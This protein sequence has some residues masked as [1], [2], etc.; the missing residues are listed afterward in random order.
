MPS[1]VLVMLSLNFASL[2]LHAQEADTVARIGEIVITAKD[3]ERA[4]ND[5]GSQF[6]R[7][8]VEQR[9]AAVL[10]ALIDIVVISQ[11][12]EAEGLAEDEALLARLALLRQRVLHNVYISR[13]V[14]DKIADDEIRALYL[15]ET[16]KVEEVKARHILVKTP[17]EAQDIIKQLNEGGNFIALAKEKSTGPTGPSG[18]LLG[19]FRK[20]R[21]VPAFEQAAFALEPGKHTA[22]PVKTQ[23]GYHVIKVEERRKV[24]PPAFETVKDQFRQ[25]ILRDRY[26]KLIKS[27][28]K[29]ASVE[30]LDEKLK[31]PDRTSK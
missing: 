9:Q 12:A 25:A 20:G 13:N 2:T 28:R 30:I 26:G 6:D 18:G 5:I 31:L 29:E 22:Q 11:K 15:E 17:K 8:P 4:R 19:F 23:F 14:T 27:A 21:M 16:G 3:L 1:L 10:N 24:A 7:L